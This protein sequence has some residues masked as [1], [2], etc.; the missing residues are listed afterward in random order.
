MPHRSPQIS[1]GLTRGQSRDAMTQPVQREFPVHRH[2][3]HLLR[4][5]KHNTAPFTYQT[6]SSEHRTIAVCV[7]VCV[8]MCVCERER[9]VQ[10]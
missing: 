10:V 5:A 2:N 8:C 7:C 6:V 1:H 3:N 4:H 9:I